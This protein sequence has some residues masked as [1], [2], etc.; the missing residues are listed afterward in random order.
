MPKPIGISLLWFILVQSATPLFAQVQAPQPASA[1]AP[2]VIRS[3]T[4]L[5]QLNV[6]VHNK[7]GDPVQGLKKED[8]TVLDQ[9]QEQPVATF[10][11]NAAGP[12]DPS[13]SATLPPNV[14]S[15]RFDQSGQ[16]P[17]SVTVILFDAL[18]TEFL[19][20]AYARQ[21]VVKFLRQLKPQDHVA[22][23][24]LTTQLT[25]LNEFTQDSSSLLR[26]IERFGGYSS[27]P[28]SA[29]NPE[30]LNPR[31]PEASRSAPDAFAS[32]LNAFLD[33]ASGRF[34]DFANINRAETTISAIEGIANHVAYV[35]GRKSLIWVSGSFPISI[36]YDADSLFQIGREHRSFGDELEH[37]ARA[38]NQANMAIYPVDARGLMTSSQYS[39]S[40]NRRFD[41]VFSPGS[42]PRFPRGG[43]VPDQNN[44]DTMTVLA[45]RT[46]GKAFYNTNDIEGAVQRA[47]A[48]GQFTYTLGFYPTH[49]KWDGKFHELKVH[50][51]EKG[52]TL[53]HRKGYFAAPDPPGGVSE[54]Q[55]ALDAA[56]W[57]PV[58]WTN[59]DLQVTLKA[60]QSS[61]RTIDLQIGLDTR[62]LLLESKDGRWTGKVYVLLSQLGE[63]NKRISGEQETFDLNLKPDT[64]EKFLKIGTKFTGRLTLSPDIVNLRV[65]AQD[66]SSGSIG[67]L[68]IPIRKLLQTASASSSKQPA[69]QK[70]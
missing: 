18:N 66:A 68:T 54:S 60:F 37:A 40:N 24:L 21:Q 31:I 4:R 25:I 58:E 23:Y 19:D 35:P 64:Y 10:S 52:L 36:G 16:A 26:A 55:A 43:L 38:L 7:K 32:Q 59:L 14:F 63:G 70:P 34:S 53:R 9:G 50:V 33:G 27:A 11:A 69:G 51:N 42:P 17:G 29:S 13:A 49:G 39:P 62:E 46:G 15:N 48:D 67:T 8:F 61:P 12:P 44:F 57:S 3:T 41:P 45:D 28:L 22:I 47:I 1:Q 20:Q 65:I 5:V 30:P 56:V 2:A 6:I